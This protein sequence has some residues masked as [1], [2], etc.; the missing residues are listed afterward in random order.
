L[1]KQDGAELL[2]A[3]ERLEESAPDY[4]TV[5]DELLEAF[6]RLAV[7]QLVGGRTDDDE[8]AA[9]EPFAGRFSAE[10]VQLYYQIALHGRR[11]LPLGRDP[12]V[13]FEMTL[14]RM[15]AFRPAVDEGASA[16]VGRDGRTTATPAPASVSRAQPAAAASAARRAA[17][18][19]SKAASAAST[20]P[21]EWPAIL[22]KLDLRGPARQ[23][24]D[25]CDLLS[26]RAGVWQ[27]VL[28]ADK[29]HLNTQQLRARLETALREQYG[30]EVRIG[31]TVG[32]P[33]RPTPAEVRRANESARMREA[34]EA[35]EADPNVQAI[36]GAFEATLEPDS[37]RSN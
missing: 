26:N 32:Q 5:L 24:A 35:I 33:T 23:L 20:P 11:D 25:S 12:R 9:L 7:L 18:E 3:A 37:I 21:A 27:L 6:Q 2:Q 22:E 16:N 10:D 4:A 34:R 17:P 19:P 1:A 8:L 13:A 31:V 15:L 36:Q 29:E 28:P 30:G 14:L